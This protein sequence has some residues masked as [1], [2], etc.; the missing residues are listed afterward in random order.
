M[1]R[2]DACRPSKGNGVGASPPPRKPRPK[3]EP[4]AQTS[5]A[6]AAEIAKKRRCTEIFTVNVLSYMSTFSGPMFTLTDELYRKYGFGDQARLRSLARLERDGFIL[7]ARRPRTAPLV[8]LL[9]TGVN[10]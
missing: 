1:G 9:N 2:L 5:L 3:A 8:T 6:K 10:W 4:F 7:V